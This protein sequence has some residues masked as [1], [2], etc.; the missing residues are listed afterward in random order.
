MPMTIN[1]AAITDIATRSV[2]ASGDRTMSSETDAN[3]VLLTTSQRLP[4]AKP[5][6]RRRPRKPSF[7]RVERDVGIIA[8][9]GRSQCPIQDDPETGLDSN[10]R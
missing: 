9:C 10:T 4:P 7:L 2:F 8:H 1:T 6:L 3:A 5:R